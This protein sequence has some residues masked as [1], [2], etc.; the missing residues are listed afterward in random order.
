M[1]ARIASCIPPPAVDVLGDRVVGVDAAH[2][3]LRGLCSQIRLQGLDQRGTDAAA[4][5]LQGAPLD[6]AQQGIRLG[7]G[8]IARS[9][10]THRESRPHGHV[11]A[12]LETARDFLLLLRLLLFHHHRRLTTTMT[13][14]ASQHLNSPLPW[15]QAL[16]RSHRL[17]DMHELADRRQVIVVDALLR[18]G[19]S[20][21]SS[22]R[23]HEPNLTQPLQ[24]RTH[25]LIGTTHHPAIL[26]EARVTPN[27]RRSHGE[28]NG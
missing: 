14:P 19:S 6:T 18:F 16:A 20:R 13:H 1:V 28:R 24:Q 22:D 27:H 8:N 9:E 7:V 11:G 17:L 12:Q 10:Q 2:P 3:E 15:S 4:R 5:S 23:T 21:V 26:Q 25:L